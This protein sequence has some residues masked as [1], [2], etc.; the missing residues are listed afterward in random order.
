MAMVSEVTAAGD[1]LFVPQDWLER[2]GKCDPY[3]KR[4]LPRPAKTIGYRAQQ[5]RA[6]SGRWWCRYMLRLGLAT[7][8]E[9]V[10][11]RGGRDKVLAEGWIANNGILC[12]RCGY[13]VGSTEFEKCAGMRMRKPGKHIYFADGCSL[14]EHSIR[15]RRNFL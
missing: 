5:K 8:G 12:A 1:Q 2:S 15:M 13:V 4:I 7:L 10:V 11:Y 3:K 14:L 6:G 9:K